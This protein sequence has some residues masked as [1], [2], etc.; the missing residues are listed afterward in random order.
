MP[1]VARWLA[2]E[3]RA[4]VVCMFAL[5]AL[6]ISA[7]TAEIEGK[8]IVDIQFRPAQPL[9]PADLEKALPLHKG[10]P[11]RADD[12]ASAID[13]LF[14]TGQFDDI[15]VEAEPSGAGVVVVFSVRNTGFIGGVNIEG[16][17]SPPPTRGDLAAA[18]QL[19]LGAPFHDQDVMQAT[20]AIKKLLVANGLYESSVTPEV[21]RMGEGEQVFITFR[22]KDRKRAKYEEP[23][24]H[25][26]V[27]HGDTELSDSTIIRATG[28]RLPI[29]HW[30][31]KVTQ[32]RTSN[33]VQGVLR[34]YAKNDHLAA[35]VEVDKLDYDPARRLVRP[36]LEIDPGPQI[37]VTSVETKVSKGKLKKYVPVYQ[38]GAADNDLLVE[39]K[40]NL[41]DYFQSKGYYD[42][43]VDFRVQPPAGGMETIEY[44]IARGQRQKLAHIAIVGNRYFT[45][46]DIRERMFMSPASFLILRHGRFSEAFERRDEQS[47]AELYRSNG[48]RDVKVSSTVQK[49][50]KGKSGEIAVTVNIGE[51]PQWLVED[52]ALE[53]VKQ[54]NR[55][56]LES[57]LASAPGQPFSETN[58]ANDRGAVLT[59]YYA[60]GFPDADFKAAWTPNGVPHH[61]NVTY[62][63]TEGERQYVRGVLVSGLRHTRPSL[64]DKRITMHPGDPLSPTQQ[65]DIQKQLYNL[66]V[67]AS[68]NTA[69]ENPDGAVDHKYVLYNLEEANRYTMTVGLGA[70][71]GTF[72]TPS[73]NSLASPTGTTGFSPAVSLDVS[74]LNFL[75]LGQ[76][77]TFAGLYSTLEQRASLSYVMPHFLDRPG[78]T[79]TYSVLW[80][81]AVNVSTFASRRAGGSVQYSHKFSKSLTGLFRF[82][83]QR[84][85]VSDVVIPVLLIPQFLQAVRVGMPSVNLVQD[86]RDNSADPHRGM[87]NSAFVGVSASVFG[88]QR[89][90]ARVLLRNATYYPLPKHWVLA[91]QTQFGVIFPFNP[92]AGISAQ[93]SVPLPERFYGGGADSMRGFAF[94]EA[95]PRDTGAP[96]VPG[97]P[98]SAPTGFPLGGNALLFNNVELRFP[99]LQQNIQGVLFHDMGNVY[100]SLD[101]I[102]LRFH[103]RNLQDF[104]YAVQAVGFGIRY[105]TPVGPIRLDLAYSINSPS[106]VGF[107]GTQLQLLQCGATGANCTPVLQ[108]TGHFQFFFSIGQM[109]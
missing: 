102:S 91:R 11:L 21:E 43:E 29:I 56:E 24:I 18:A 109:F 16:K 100:G 88:S 89:D 41:T 85:S 59:Y 45:T 104:D 1:P 69:V 19:N 77:M 67:F 42:V 34:K 23:L 25:G 108:N 73:S 52:L 105:R 5:G 36:D 33:G 44:A 55:E 75:G 103:Q 87:Y 35:K 78:D 30:W 92:P 3:V 96:L 20:E 68:V 47:I 60:H 66:D 101:S 99:F 28:W 38:E 6:P 64:V 61:V 14:A 54:G 72:G 97:G 81:N 8:Q 70:Q 37:K 94:N 84:V 57:N 17:P 74:R 63:V 39:G 90:F 15:V 86:R 93:E 62:T 58:L 49:N 80:D 12:V 9:D 48:F 51:G 32:A 4:G 22:I 50:Y 106:F 65:I 31:R 82:A 83:Y 76:T 2:R 13:S 107:K 79:I 26:N 10:S 53:G 46:E 27:T 7:Q 98:S 40:R 71:V 95:G